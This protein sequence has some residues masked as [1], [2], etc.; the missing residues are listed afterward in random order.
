MTAGMLER[1]PV[2]RIGRRAQHARPGRTILTVITAVLFGL[3]WVMASSLRFAGLA[4]GWAAA[5]IAEG[6]SEGLRNGRGAPRAG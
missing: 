2:D 4:L 1:V 6:F 5:A 3:G